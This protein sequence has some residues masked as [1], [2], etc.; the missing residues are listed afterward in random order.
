MHETCQKVSLTEEQLLS[1]FNYFDTDSS[2]GDFAL[3]FSLLIY[4]HV[5][6]ESQGLVLMSFWLELE[7]NLMLF[8]RNLL[9][10]HGRFVFKC[11]IIL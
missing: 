7:G 10:W 11:E 2:G 4:F 6:S 9:I 5:N 1:V 8:V 3:F